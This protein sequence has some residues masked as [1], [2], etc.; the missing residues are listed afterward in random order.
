MGEKCVS[1][2][3]EGAGQ[4]G[5]PRKTWKEVVVD[6]GMNDLR[7]KLSEAMDCSIREGVIIEWIE[8]Q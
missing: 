2:E 4:R 6:K 7:L 3:A 1:L 8:R 5:R